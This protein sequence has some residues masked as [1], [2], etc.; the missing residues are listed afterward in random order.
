MQGSESR[1]EAAKLPVKQHPELLMAAREGDLPRLNRLLGVVHATD[2]PVPA[3]GAGVVVNI[4]V[5]NSPRPAAETIAMDLELNQI[6][7]VAASSGDSPNFL[8][9]AR[10][11]YGKAG[12]LLDA[13]NEKGDTPF[14]CAA[15]AGMVE[16]VSLLVGLARAEGGGDRVKAALRKLNKQGETALHEALRL[17]E[18]KAVDA[19]VGRLMEADAELARVPPANGTSPLYLAVLLRHDDIAERLH[20]QDE[21][22]SYSGPNG[23][24]ALHAAVLR[25]T[26]E[27]L[28]TSHLTLHQ[29]FLIRIIYDFPCISGLYFVTYFRQLTAQKM[30]TMM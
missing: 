9:S 26:C 29:F 25:S 11:I 6:L 27:Y 22:L 15:R 3:A 23:Q 19:M 12:H 2:Q 21:G 16:M 8:E 14:H 7:H 4:T 28:I 20:R 1:D 5:D 18:K 24:N 10:A 30:F 17:A 13:C